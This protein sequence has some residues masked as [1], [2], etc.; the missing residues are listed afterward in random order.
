MGVFIGF[1]VFRMEINLMYHFDF[2]LVISI[3][4][5]D[6]FGYIHRVCSIGVGAMIIRSHV[7]P[8]VIEV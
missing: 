8:R 3:Y 6:I 7:C 5:S 4:S 1:C 2:G